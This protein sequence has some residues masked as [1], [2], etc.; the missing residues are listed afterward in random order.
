[1]KLIVCDDSRSDA[2]ALMLLC[3]TYLAEHGYEAEVKVV[4]D[5]FSI[6]AGQTDILI[7]DIEMPE[8]D[9]ITLKDKLAMES[10]C[11]LI[12]FA[13]RYADAMSKAFN[14]NVIGFL[15]KPVDPR[16]LR[17]MLDLAILHLNLDREIELS[18]GRR[19]NTGEIVRIH[20][21]R[22]YTVLHLASG[23]Q[24][25]GGRKSLEQWEE[26]LTEQGFLRIEKSCIVSSRHI[27]SFQD[28]RIIL[29]E[30]DRDGEKICLRVSR[31]RKKDCYQQYLCY[32]SRIAKFV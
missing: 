6:K 15:L 28:D 24:E 23:E 7:L 21:D 10:D 18:H 19:V 26:E 1:M 32:L 16:L 12:I 27:K 2:Q 8:L 9:G 29:K 22:G 30:A 5:P 31:R 25:D 11:P 4:T 14:R 3:E 13:T 17:D 20:A